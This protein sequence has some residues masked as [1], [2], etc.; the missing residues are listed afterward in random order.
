LTQSKRKTL[1]RHDL[2]GATEPVGGYA[3]PAR[4]LHNSRS[5]VAIVA[6]QEPPPYGDGRIRIKALARVDFL[7]QMRRMALI[8][9]A[10]LAAGREVERKLER[11]A[12]I[13]CGGQW[14]EGDR[15]DAATAHDVAL[16]NGYQ[17]SLEVNGFLGWLVHELGRRDARLVCKVLG[18]RKSFKQCAIDEGKSGDRGRRYMAERFRDALETLAK[19]REAKGKERA[20]TVG[21]KFDDE[22]KP[23]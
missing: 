1:G 6:V 2:A 8:D 19:A 14:R 10:M 22:G 5:R 7:D 23:A 15:V 21:M 20:R 11:G 13:G 16:R 9:E 3:Q 12:R 17:R 4:S 18:D